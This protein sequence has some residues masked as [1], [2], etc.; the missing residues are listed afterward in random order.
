MASAV[1]PWP[2]SEDDLVLQ[3]LTLTEL[4]APTLSARSA[5]LL[6]RSLAIR[7]VYCLIL[8]DPPDADMS[9]A[10]GELKESRKQYAN[11]VAEIRAGGGEVTEDEDNFVVHALRL[12]R[13]PK[14]LQPSIATCNAPKFMQVENMLN[15]SRAFL[16]DMDTGRLASLK[17]LSSFRGIYPSIAY[18]DSLTWVDDVLHPFLS[19]PDCDEGMLP[20]LVRTLRVAPVWELLVQLLTV[21]LL[22]EAMAKG[23]VERSL[24]WTGGACALILLLLLRSPPFLRRTSAY[25]PYFL[26][27]PPVLITS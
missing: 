15:G 4:A 10:I 9:R 25:L 18:E 20:H 23:V 17:V 24:K 21:L 19:L 11:E 27:S 14:G 16:M 5:E 7:R 22:L 1:I 8:L 6:C 12:W 3:L 2:S 26:F 13:Q